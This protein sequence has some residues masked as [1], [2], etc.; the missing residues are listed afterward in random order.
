MLRKLPKKIHHELKYITFNHHAPF[1]VKYLS[2]TCPKDSEFSA[3]IISSIYFDTHQLFAA[4]EKVNSDFFKSKV[5]LRWYQTIDNGEFSEKSYLEIKMKIGARRE[6]IRHEYH[7]SGKEMSETDFSKI[8]LID[9]LKD[10]D[11][12]VLSDYFSY[13][14]IIQINYKRYRF[15]DPLTQ[16]RICIDHDINISRVNQNIFN[17]ISNNQ[18]KYC[19]FE[20]KGPQEVLP[21][22]LSYL[23][24][25]GLQKNAFSKY[26]HCLQKLM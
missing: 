11:Q 18:L 2:A 10:M 7:R 5:R 14:P 22:S 8:N 19:V 12:D 25:Y 3:G 17:P 20:C 4:N 26:Y 23:R 15:I 13:I 9:I 6:K 16:S 21:S 24:K 1:L